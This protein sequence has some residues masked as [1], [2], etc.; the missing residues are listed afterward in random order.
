[1]NKHIFLMGMAAAMFMTS[2]TNEDDLAG[3]SNNQRL[4]S[5]VPIVLSAGQQANKTRA[6]L[7]NVGADGRYDGTFDTPA[8]KN[9]GFFCLATGKIAAKQDINW[10]KGFDNPNFLWLENIQAKAVTSYDADLNKKVTNL[11]LFD[12]NGG[13]TEAKHYYPMGSQYSYTFYGYYPYSANVE[14]NG[15]KYSVKITG[16]DGT[17]DLIWGKSFVDPNDPDKA[18]AYSA[19]YLRDKKKSV[20]AKGETW[21]AKAHKEN[22]PNL[23]FVHKLMKFNIIL[24][25]GSGENTR[26]AKL[27]IKSAKLLNVADAGTLTIADLNNRLDALTDDVKGKEGEFVVDWTTA[28]NHNT[29]ATAFELK[30]KDG[31]VIGNPTNGPYL[32]DNTE[33]TVGDGFL[34]PVPTQIGTN[35]DGSTKYEDN[36]YLGTDAAEFANKGIFRLRVEYYLE[37]APDKV[38]KAAQYEITPK[39]KEAADEVWQ[40][41]YEYD[42][43][44]SVSDPELIQTYGKLTPWGKRTI[45]LE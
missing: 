3:G 18:D 5:D 15:N 9:L 14:H 37:D 38:Y 43:K 33:V 6:S 32:G 26:V 16:L 10:Q 13:T 2:C 11:T 24:K 39:F 23:T 19:K 12:E 45:E 22:R 34:I 44:I 30:D 1:M 36:G 40:A 7:G 8:D 35:A 17:T 28:K 21:D 31:N 42:I 25:K 20:E 4:N 29:K 27:G 41:G